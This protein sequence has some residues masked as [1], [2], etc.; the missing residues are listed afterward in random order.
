M[1][2]R[3]FVLI[4]G[5]RVAFLSSKASVCVRLVKSLFQTK[6]WIVP[7]P[8]GPLKWNVGVKK[9]SYSCLVPSAFHLRGIRV[10]VSDQVFLHQL[11]SWISGSI[12]L[13]T[14]YVYYLFKSFWSK[15]CSNRSR[16]VF[17]SS[18]LF[19]SIKEEFYTFLDQ[20]QAYS[21]L[22]ENFRTKLDSL[23][24]GALLTVH[25]TERSNLKLLSAL[26]SPLKPCWSLSYSFL[27]KPKK[28]FESWHQTSYPRIWHTM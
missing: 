18:W 4:S 2:E 8:S 11:D 3:F 10:E 28:G 17:N 21:V 5:K 12:S 15:P 23:K 19:N 27:L 22:F 13:Y 26:S 20:F 14:T 1:C 7:P 9:I 24:T 16:A 6:S 25:S